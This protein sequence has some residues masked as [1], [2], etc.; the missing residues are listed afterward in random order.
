M[1]RSQL[2]TLLRNRDLESVLFNDEDEDDAEEIFSRW[3]RRRRRPAKDPN[4]FPK[5]PSAAGAKLME[6][7]AF[8]ATDYNKR[9]HKHLMRRMFERELG[10]GDL[11]ARQRNAAMITQ[12]SPLVD[13]VARCQLLNIS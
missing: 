5:V 11:A 4:R 8:G 12:V 13:G 9:A 3:G 7:G 10:D 6:S 2:L 1:T